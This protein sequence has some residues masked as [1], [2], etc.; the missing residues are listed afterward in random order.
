MSGVP[1]IAR[2][3]R[4]ESLRGDG[5]RAPTVR[6]PRVTPR[7][8]AMPT[9]AGGSLEFRILGPLEV[10][11]GGR[12]V[13]LQGG[14]QR[15]LLAA[16]LLH[17]N[18]PVSADRLIDELWGPVAGAGAGKRLQMA[19]SRLRRALDQ[20]TAEAGGESVLTTEP[21]GYVLHLAPGALDAYRFEQLVEQ[22]QR[23]AQAE[24]HQ[25]AAE[26]VD[27]GLSLWRGPALSDLAFASFAQ[28]E[29]ARLEEMRQ[30]TMEDRIDAELAR[31][32]HAAMIAELQALVTHHPARERS[33][34]QL[35]L[36]LYRA[37]RQADALQAYRT[38]RAWSVE[39]LGLEPGP[40]LRALNDAILRHDPQLLYERRPAAADI[41]GRGADRH[42]ARRAKV[43]AQQIARVTDGEGAEH[44]TATEHDKRLHLDFPTLPVALVGRDA[45]QRTVTELARRP[46]GRLVTITGPGGVGKTSLAFAVAREI[47]AEFRE[48]ATFVDLAGISEP[49]ELPATV[50]QT[51]GGRPE[52]GRAPV[53]TLRELLRA[54]HQILV[55]DNL[56]HLLPAGPLVADF[57]QTAP[58]VVVLATSRE[59]LALRGE[60]VY[61]LGALGP[62]HAVELFIERAQDYTPKF[63]PE[64][65]E[66][67]A[68][69][70]LCRHLDGLPL[71]IELTAPYVALLPI[72]DLAARLER[73]LALLH[74]QTRD[75]PA[76]HRTLRATIDWSY[77]LLDADAQRAFAALAACA[78]GCT[79]DAALAISQ[80]D[81]ETLAAL[82]G[83]SLLVRRG[84]RLAMLE[85]LR[86]YALE[87]LADQS[88]AEEIH[89]RHAHVY[90]A[91]AE[92]GE[93]GL[94]GPE[95]LFWRRR[96]EAETDNFRGALSW[97]LERGQT[98]LALAL[99][100]VLQ[101]FWAVTWRAEEGH[102]WL[103]MALSAGGAAAS[104]ERVRA[105]ALLARS[106]QA[107]LNPRRSEDAAR[108]ALEL[109]NHLDDPIGACECVLALG[110]GEVVRGRYEQATE[111]ANHA[112]HTARALGEDRL[113]A[114]ALLVRVMASSSPE[115]IRARTDEA[116]GHLRRTGT[117]RGIA[118]LLTTSSYF[119]IADACYVH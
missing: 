116:L 21:G 37:G 104:S 1:L 75:A 25:T 109:Y 66:R 115:Q 56:E 63:D 69:A 93:A 24:E 88:D 3:E 44:L 59:P 98:E 101:E 81:I 18:R 54:R 15:A 41:P 6:Q 7:W 79:V 80:A 32:R 112:L 52:S 119:A 28:G 2:S 92:H 90:L 102:R 70:E 35:M 4:R 43:T 23:A 16:L 8:I 26:R 86:E 113:I 29:I 9:E 110:H 83:K 12:R 118:R 22:G 10:C 60:R 89:A 30:A 87:R 97:A 82:H 47:A 105:R 96:L 42:S 107:S 67:A 36:A 5:H 99:A 76:R 53:E 46:H 55:L 71:A 31:G 11:S 62:A 65:S 38:A 49:Q 20:V 51:L 73:P 45:D 106:R 85:T 39:H 13:A 77:R 117:T 27:E 111:V 64:P 91:L 48:G 95:W 94:L 61:P 19:I 17:A 68:L 100:A 108:A 40:Q 84:D 14:A 114:E 103:T 74:S 33:R 50:L 57:V 58:D 78:G 72:A 34:A